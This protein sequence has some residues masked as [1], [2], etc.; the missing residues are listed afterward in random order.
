MS[1]GRGKIARGGEVLNKLSKSVGRFLRRQFF[2]EHVTFEG[3]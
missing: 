3:A 2:R 1:H